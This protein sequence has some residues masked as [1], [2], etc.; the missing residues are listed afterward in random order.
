MSRVG[1]A[2]QGRI[3]REAQEAFA[4]VAL[5]IEYLAH[6]IKREA[7]SLTSLP[8]EITAVHVGP[9]RTKQRE[10]ISIDISEYGDPLH[11]RMIRMPFTNYLKPWVTGL[12]RDLGI[13]HE[14]PK[15]RA[16]PLHEIDVRQAIKVRQVRKEVLGLARRASVRIPLQEEGTKRLMDEYLR[17]SLR[18]FHQHYYSTR[19]DPRELWAQTYT[20]API[21]GLPQCLRDIL[22]W[23][24]DRLLKPAGIQIVTRAFLAEGWHPRHIAGLIRSKFEDPS[25]GWGLG[26][27]DY[28]AGTRADFYVRLFSGLWATGVDE[29][30][31]FN[32]TSTQEKGFCPVPHTEPCSLDPL[33]KKLAT[34]THL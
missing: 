18:R 8:V 31:D 33:R 2:W 25:F 23:P 30:V 22:E 34:P 21:G 32:C 24:N 26:W 13:E 14:V 4:G 6:V 29:L 15:M 7:A 10:M 27:D 17:S 19:H 3:H 20:R 12:A 5:V 1:D 11:T 28:E 16:I 9:V